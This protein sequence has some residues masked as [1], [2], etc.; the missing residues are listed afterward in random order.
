MLNKS[1]RVSG[2]RHP[3][4]GAVATATLVAL[5][6]GAAGCS[7]SGSKSKAASTSS[8][9]SSSHASN[10]SSKKN[11]STN[12]GSSGLSPVTAQ[13]V[14]L[15]SGTP[16]QGKPAITI[17]DKNFPEEFLLGDL[18]QTALKAKGYTVKLK[19]NIGGSEIIDTSFKSGQIDLYP[20]YL[21]EIVTSVA[22]KNPQKTNVD[23]YNAAKKF[24]KSK[25]KATIL[26]QT[27]FQD[28]DTLFVKTA[29]A[30]KYN[31]KS[32][33]D[34]KNV[35]AKGQG[36]TYVAQ[37]PNRT[38]F[39]GL[40][41]LQKAYGLTD[42]KFV[43]APPGQQYKAINKGQ[44]NVGDAF[45]TDP[46]FASGVNAGKYVALNDTKHIMGFQHVAPVVKQSILKSEG[47]QFAKTLN[48]VSSLLTLKAVQTMD[49]AVQTKHKDAA[50]VAKQ[51]LEANGLNS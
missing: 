1:G 6:L 8:S 49:I 2:A 45:S 18:Y 23:T 43:G 27:P 20:E 10:S 37:P 11:S 5:S 28:V 25:R 42:V 12:S 3:W 40:K 46:A 14:T 34:L 41:G 9:S 38:R 30:K 35:G 33:A 4:R 36:V 26:K 50:T 17:G 51:F 24:E 48:W 31:L 44:G 7:N 32:A 21:G 29:F 47:P 16:G 19:P 39:A 15:P 22:K 13:N